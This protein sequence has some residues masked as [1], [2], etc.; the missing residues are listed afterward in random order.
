[1]PPRRAGLHAVSAARWSLNGTPNGRREAIDCAACEAARQG[2]KAGA[3]APEGVNMTQRT[4]S[5]ADRRRVDVV[6]RF[7]KDPRVVAL[8]QAMDAFGVRDEVI[9]ARHIA[10]ALRGHR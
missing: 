10:R 3:K 8:N 5:L 2:T 6:K 4:I 1:M 7:A 9:R